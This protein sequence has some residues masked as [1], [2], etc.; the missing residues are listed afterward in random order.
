M[1]VCRLNIILFNFGIYVI[2]LEIGILVFFVAICLI[3]ILY[4]LWQCMAFYTSMKHA[5]I[6]IYNIYIF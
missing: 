1:F 2:I 3:S 6:Y 4:K 5:R